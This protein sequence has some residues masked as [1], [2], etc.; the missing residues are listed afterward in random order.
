M[1]STSSV[2]STGFARAAGDR[3][4]YVKPHGAL[5][6]TIVRHEQQAAAVV[7]A[8]VAFDPSL[9]VLCLSGSR[10]LALAE[11]AGLPV[12]TEAFADRAYTADGT[13]VSR[14]EAGAVL[15]DAGQVA[16]RCVAMVKEG[17]VEAIDGSVVEVHADS[18]CVHGDTPG[19][20][21]L[22]SAVRRALT[23]ADVTLRPFVADGR[24]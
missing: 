20:T 14:R 17:R 19:A 12:H 23:D 21:A 6:N 22:A 24:A 16:E 13:L 4:R 7:D 8:V 3:V 1:S 11:E 9:A 15:T 10:F 2:R 5:Y 18:I